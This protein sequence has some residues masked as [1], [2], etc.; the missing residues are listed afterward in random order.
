MIS[1][2]VQTILDIKRILGKREVELLVPEKSTVEDLLRNMVERW[3]DELSSRLFE[4]GTRRLFSHIQIMV[5]GRA[6]GFLNRMETVLQDGDEVL[7][8]PPAAGG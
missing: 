2:K 1:V 4:P 8:L 5:N 6:I 3:G 7:L